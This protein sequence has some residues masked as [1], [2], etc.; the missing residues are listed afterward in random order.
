MTNNRN[1]N[2]AASKPS[3]DLDPAANLRELDRVADAFPSVAAWIDRLDQQ[4]SESMFRAWKAQLAKC[5]LADVAAVVDRMIGGEIEL[6]ENYHFDRL[7]VIVREL[8]NGL[9]HRRQQAET[10]AGR[11]RPRAQLAP[12]VEAALKAFRAGRRVHPAN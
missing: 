11:R 9:S 6:P 8:A 3:A 10:M 7:A 2:A 4:Q 12:E 1:E 5:Q